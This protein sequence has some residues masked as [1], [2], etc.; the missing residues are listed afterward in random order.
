MMNERIQLL[1][2]QAGMLFD[3]RGRPLWV[4]MD[5]VD[6]DNFLEEFYRVIVQE[7]AEVCRKQSLHYA[8]HNNQGSAS[9][10]ADVC[11]ILIKS[12]FGIE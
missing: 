3:E 6:K 11:K 1:A 7:S 8:E 12:H 4:A 10:A 5:R 2:E 9:S